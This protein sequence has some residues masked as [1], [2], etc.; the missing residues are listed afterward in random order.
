[1]TERTFVQCLGRGMWMRL[2]SR[3]EIVIGKYGKTVPKLSSWLENKFEEDF[4]VYRPAKSECRHIGTSKMLERY[5][6]KLGKRLRGGLQA[7][8]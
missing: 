7:L 3:P 5:D 1:V 8:A 6:R 2:G 4:V